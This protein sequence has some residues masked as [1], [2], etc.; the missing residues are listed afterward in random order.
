MRQLAGGSLVG[1]PTVPRRAGRA[2]RAF[3]LIELLVVI[4][5]IGLLAT[6]LLPALGVIKNRAKAARAQA[7]IK[8]LSD[9]AYMYKEATGY[10]PGQLYPE[11]LAGSG[12]LYTGSQVLAACMFNF[13]LDALNPE[14]TE[15]YASL[16]PDDLIE[17]KG[18]KNTISD[19]FGR[20]EA[21]GAMAILYYPARLDSTGLNQFR[22]LD[23]DA[24]T[25]G[26]T[27][28]NRPGGAAGS[29]FQQYIRNYTLYGASSSTPYNAGE[30]LLLAAGSDRKYGTVYDVKNW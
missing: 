15:E 29:P 20:T 30:F 4:A 5:I 19:R 7:R 2:G 9:G 3:T 24:Y 25:S 27:W 1:R 17:I 11:K 21:D 23:N 12:G 22:E 10:F 13:S 6:L 26:S 14:P 16:R 18:R 8:E 28:D